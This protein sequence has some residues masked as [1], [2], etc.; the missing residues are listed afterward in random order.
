MLFKK[1]KK[2]DFDF[3]FVEE[4]IKNLLSSNVYL[5]EEEKRKLISGNIVEK[6]KTLFDIEEREIFYW[7]EFKQNYP[8]AIFAI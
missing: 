7:H 8:V 5:T 2:E 1:N 3:S 4:K 6:L